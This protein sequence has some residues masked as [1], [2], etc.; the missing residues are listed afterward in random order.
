M[1]F[2]HVDS[3]AAENERV[4][5]DVSVRRGNEHDPAWFAGVS[6]L[7]VADPECDLII[8]GVNISG[9]VFASRASIELG[10]KSLII[11]KRDHVGGNC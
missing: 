3:R 6:G 7:K 8:V 2:V 9:C 5:M 10:L 11:D 4:G 1:S